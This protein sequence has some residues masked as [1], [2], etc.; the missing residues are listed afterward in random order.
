GRCWRGRCCRGCSA[1]DD[2][3][4]PRRHAVRRGRRRCFGLRLARPEGALAHLLHHHRL[5][6]AM[7]ETLTH[8]AR[9]GARL[10]RQ[11]LGRADAQRLLAGTFRISSHSHPILN[12]KPKPLLIQRAATRY[13]VPR[14]PGSI[15]RKRSR[16]W[17]RARNPLL[18]GPASRAACTTFDRPNAKS[19]CGDVNVA[20]VGTLPGFSPVSRRAAAAALLRAPSGEPS[21][22]VRIATTGPEATAASV[23]ENP[24]ATR[25]ALWTIARASSAAFSS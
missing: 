24:I 22:A 8:D 6:A 4:A 2:T 5:G 15:I 18:A 9:L 16:F 21:E 20:I 7:A 13:P 12:L 1:R 14:P 10:E 23:L 19:N 3:N 25:E 17:Q 11:R